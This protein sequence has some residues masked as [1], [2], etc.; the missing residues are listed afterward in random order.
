MEFRISELP[1][2]S[3]APSDSANCV[4][5]DTR[6]PRDARRASTPI[7]EQQSK[8]ATNEELFSRFQISEQEFHFA[9]SMITACNLQ[10]RKRPHL[11]SERNKTRPL[12]HERYC[13]LRIRH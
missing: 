8:T 3:L 12:A 10:P 11:E 2:A 6:I 13:P 7:S 1:A 4:R 5:T 9:A